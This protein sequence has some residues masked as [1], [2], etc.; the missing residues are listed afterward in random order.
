MPI[1]ELCGREVQKTS[2]HH[3]LPKDEGGRYT[4]TA[5]LCQPCHSTI[6]NIFT[7]KELAKKFT[8]LTALKES[9]EMQSYLEWIK[10]K[11]IEKLT[12]RKKKY[13]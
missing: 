4:Q 8:S 11:K 3:L 2:R 13:K 7:N 12:F 6:H 9:E 5:N 1:C 10:N